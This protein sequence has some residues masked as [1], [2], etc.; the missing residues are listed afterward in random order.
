MK[1]ESCGVIACDCPVPE[2]DVESKVE[3]RKMI[4][5]DDVIKIIAT[6]KVTRSSFPDPLHDALTQP[7]TQLRAIEAIL[8]L[9][10]VA[11]IDR[12]NRL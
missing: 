10:K 3:Y 1:C 7:E 12:I 11:L 6:M 2:P 5:R 8:Q 4:C 9:A